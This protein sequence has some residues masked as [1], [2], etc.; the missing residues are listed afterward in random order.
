M[1]SDILGGSKVLLIGNVIRQQFKILNNWNTGSGLSLVL[2]VFIVITMAI[3]AKY[4]NSENKSGGR[5][6]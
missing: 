1:I 4:D 6:L 3:L 5:V 2:M